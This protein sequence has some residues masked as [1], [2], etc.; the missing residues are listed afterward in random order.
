MAWYLYLWNGRALSRNYFESDLMLQGVAA[1]GMG[2][3][4][5]RMHPAVAQQVSRAFDALFID[6]MTRV[7]NTQIISSI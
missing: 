2:A 1:G 7:T 4:H 3:A 5:E 6:G